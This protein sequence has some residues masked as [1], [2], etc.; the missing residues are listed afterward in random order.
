MCSP[1]PRPNDCRIRCGF[2]ADMSARANPILCHCCSQ[3]DILGISFYASLM[4]VFLYVLCIYE[5]S[6]KCLPIPICT[7]YIYIYFTT[8]KD[9]TTTTD[10]YFWST[11]RTM[12][13]TYCPQLYRYLYLHCHQGISFQCF[14]S[15]EEMHI[16]HCEYNI[17]TNRRRTLICFYKMRCRET[18]NE[19][20]ISK[21]LQWTL[22]RTTTR[23][24]LRLLKCDYMDVLDQLCAPSATWYAF[25][26]ICG[27]CDVHDYYAHHYHKLCETS[28]RN[29][30]I[31]V[32]P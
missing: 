30:Y 27:Y 5:C 26:F 16:A 15:A 28:T 7:V 17:W 29:L 22:R 20:Y 31:Y 23:R 25:V 13:S 1:I 2:W 3:V 19:R 8:I 11:Y 12:D 10:K 9:N 21:P 14:C 24:P 4:I 32:L 6:V 18:C